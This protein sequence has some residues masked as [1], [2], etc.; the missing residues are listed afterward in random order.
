MFSCCTTRKDS[1]GS[2]GCP[3]NHTAIIRADSGMYR[4]C[5][6]CP[7]SAKSPDFAATKMGKDKD[8]LISKK[9]MQTGTKSGD[10][11]QQLR[12]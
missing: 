4:E 5:E 3:V 7:S 8:L 6:I 10:F 9:N 1:C 12:F 2:R 11:V